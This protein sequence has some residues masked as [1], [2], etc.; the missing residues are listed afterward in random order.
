MGL[1]CDGLNCLVEEI[2]DSITLRYAMA[3]TVRKVGTG[4]NGTRI[5]L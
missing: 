1:N 3:V 4:E 2:Q 5:S